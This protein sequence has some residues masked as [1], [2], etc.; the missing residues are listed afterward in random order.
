MT[1]DDLLMMLWDVA[2]GQIERGEAIKK[3]AD[4]FRS[5]DEEKAKIIAATISSVKEDRELLAEA[6]E[7]A[8]ANG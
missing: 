5:M 8:T 3:I 6:I 4:H 1:N 7:A 2:G